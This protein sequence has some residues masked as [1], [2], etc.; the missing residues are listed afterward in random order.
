MTNLREHDPQP[1][2]AGTD[3]LQQITS[4]LELVEA[5]VERFIAPTTPARE[6]LTVE[7][8]SK[9]VTRSVWT[10]RRWCRDGRIQA[11]KTVCGRGVS[12]EWRVSVA[13]LQRYQ[14]EG[15]LP[16]NCGSMARTES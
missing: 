6:W 2:S 10:V 3:R 9:S 14:R 12:G 4:R 7:E 13:E 15:L 5:K 16:S 8:F 1:T 11:H